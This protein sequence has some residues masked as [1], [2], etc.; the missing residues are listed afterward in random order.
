MKNKNPYNDGAQISNCGVD[1]KQ[2]K[3]YRKMLLEGQD[4]IDDLIENGL[5]KYEIQ[6][7]LVGYVIQALK[8]NKR[9][10]DR[11]KKGKH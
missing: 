3:Q 1:K 7:A 4:I 11:T 10:L 9:E 5:V 2:L 6:D 8:S